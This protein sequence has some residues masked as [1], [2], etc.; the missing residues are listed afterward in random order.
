MLDAI[1]SLIGQ[2]FYNLTGILFLLMDV[3]QG[4][5][6]SFA[7]V[8]TVYYGQWTDV[9]PDKITGA[10]TGLEQE[11][12][13]VYYLLTSQLVKNIFLSIALLA[14]FLIIVFMVMAFIKNSYV[15]KPKSWKD[16]V[17]SAIKGLTNF[18]FIPVCCLLGV[19]LGNI[20]LNAIDGATSTGGAL[21]VS[22]KIFLASAYNANS[23]REG[24][25]H[26]YG[27]TIE[28]SEA[29]EIQALCDHVFGSGKYVVEIPSSD[30]EGQGSPDLEYYANIVDQCF[31]ADWQN[32]KNPIPIWTRVA[33][34]GGGAI[35][36]KANVAAW[37]D[38]FEFNYLLLVAGGIF[39]MSVL[40]NLTYG[41]VKRMF[42]LLMLFVISPA[43]CA[44]Y[45]LDDGKAVGSLKGDFVKNTISAYGAVAG[46][47]LFFSFSPLI[48]NINLSGMFGTRFGLAMNNFFL[49]DIIHILLLICGL[50]VVNDFVN[51]ISGYIGAGNALSDGKSLRGNVKGAVKKYAGGAIKK[52]TGAF[53]AIKKANAAKLEGGSSSYWW[54]SMGAST[55]DGIKGIGTNITTQALGLDV[56]K[57]ILD[58]WQGAEYAGI[59]EAKQIKAGKYNEAKVQKIFRGRVLDGAGSVRSDVGLG[60]TVDAIMDSF[61]DPVFELMKGDSRFGFYGTKGKDWSKVGAENK[62]IETI[63]TLFA[64]RNTAVQSAETFRTAHQTD[65][66]L[67]FTALPNDV[68]QNAIKTGNQIDASAALPDLI[69]YYMSSAGGSLSQAAATTEANSLLATANEYLR[70]HLS[71]VR[72]VESEMLPYV[73]QHLDDITD[74]GLKAFF[75]TEF[76][77]VKT[78]LAT[79]TLHQT[80]EVAR[81]GSVTRTVEEMVTEFHDLA[82]DVAKIIDTTE[83]L[84]KIG[85]K[86]EFEKGKK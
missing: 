35:G 63:A 59:K 54:K 68:A 10:N 44:M 7:G 50:Y 82:E 69:S 41:M 52:T 61:R 9:N 28:K 64:E 66:D 36:A 77:K 60:T 19:W 30:V 56:Q 22:R 20:L 79:T 4:L 5:F 26:K 29:E 27:S 24:N 13:I 58:K 71:Q 15:D 53:N 47:N 51:M 86:I 81:K 23:I 11:T 12:G 39:T 33:N 40:V 72:S 16:I 49:N 2:L 62:A 65:L 78:E 17:S 57:D 48:E 84:T 32:A 21:S 38:T 1:T 55:L 70:N 76:G 73:G 46:M 34:F 43:L 18:I 75:S 85:K 42:I 67:F 80:T 14:I 83:E 45:P 31:G 25:N 6:R 74:A 37:Y 3:L 8:G